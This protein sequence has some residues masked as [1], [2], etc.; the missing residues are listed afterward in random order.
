MTNT[1]EVLQKI[2]DDMQDRADQANHVMNDLSRITG[3]R[4]PEIDQ[5]MHD[6]AKEARTLQEWVYK[7]RH[8]Y[9]TQDMADDI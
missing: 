6:Y 5:I 8:E 3:H 4:H 2:A 7:I 1:Y 9:T